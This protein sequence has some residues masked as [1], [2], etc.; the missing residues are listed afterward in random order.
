MPGLLEFRDYPESL[1]PLLHIFLSPNLV[2]LVPTYQQSCNWFFPQRGK[3]IPFKINE[4]LDEKLLTWCQ[5]CIRHLA[6]FVH[7]ILWWGFSQNKFLNLCSLNARGLDNVCISWKNVTLYFVCF[8][9]LKWEFL[10]K[11]F[12]KYP[13]DIIV[14]IM[15]CRWFHL[16]KKKGWNYSYILMVNLKKYFIL[17]EDN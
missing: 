8:Q 5:V 6:D 10:L 3:I 15:W 2:L 1:L 9:N 16:K 13:L 12:F 11:V 7:V 4:I 14:A 17:E